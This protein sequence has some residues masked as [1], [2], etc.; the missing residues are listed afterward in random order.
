MIRRTITTMGR[1]LSTQPVVK[2]SFFVSGF[3]SLRYNSH[4]GSLDPMTGKPI[5]ESDSLSV[6]LLAIFFK[7]CGSKYW[8]DVDRLSQVFLVAVST[9]WCFE[10][11][12]RRN[13]PPGWEEKLKVEEFD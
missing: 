11:E 2:I 1:E 5:S 6:Y 13:N 9:R 12:M 8:T 7:Y 3:N 10:N 4:I